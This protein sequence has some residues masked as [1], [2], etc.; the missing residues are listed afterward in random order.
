MRE[1]R[2]S[3]LAG[4]SAEILRRRV[5]PVVVA[6]ALV[7]W[8]LLQI[9]EV[10]FE[11]LGL[12]DWAMSVLVAAAIAGFPIAV[13]LSWMFDITPSGIRRDTQEV[14]TDS[15]FEESP[16]IAVL[17][18]TDMSPN[19]DQGYFC[20]GVAEA[21][22]NALTMVEGLH[23]AAR[24]S[25]FRYESVDGDAR[26]IG[27]SLGV[28]TILEGSVRKSGNRLRVTAQLVDVDDGYH[29]WSQTFDREL[30]DIFA[31]QDEIA[32]NIAAT[33]VKSIVSIVT[34][35]TSDAVAY[36]FYLRG[37]KFLKRF[38]KNDFEFARQM[39]RHA[40]D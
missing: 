5:Y 3:F 40:I 19:K 30:K 37:K 2:H 20:E 10:T 33:L 16:S 15:T 26:V 25:S 31:I 12:P 29:I 34:S 11:P 24:V 8:A 18:F 7:A 32:T 35:G 27:K 6:Y 22:L 36:D 4:I 21:I 9:G 14:A 28:K 23:V 39:F 1:R 13:I 38:S 17:P